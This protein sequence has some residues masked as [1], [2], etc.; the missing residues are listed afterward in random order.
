MSI[1]YIFQRI[2]RQIFGTQ[3]GEQQISPLRRFRLREMVLLRDEALRVLAC[4]K[5]LGWRRRGR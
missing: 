3:T 5:W 2:G 1:T 4:A